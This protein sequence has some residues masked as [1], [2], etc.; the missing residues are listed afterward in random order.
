[1]LP[2]E[3]R[4]YWSRIQA[5]EENP[6]EKAGRVKCLQ[7]RKAVS[8]IRLH[9]GT[10]QDGAL[11]YTYKNDLLLCGFR[12]IYVHAK[13]QYIKTGGFEN[14]VSKQGINRKPA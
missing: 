12:V 13:G 6:S 8:R 2:F 10:A 3:T 9:K 7:G 5:A 4:L 14:E 11:L 1:M